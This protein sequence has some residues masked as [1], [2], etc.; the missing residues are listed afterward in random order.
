MSPIFHRVG[1]A[2][3]GRGKIPF[4]PD[5]ITLLGGIKMKAKKIVS[6]VL[7]AAVLAAAGAPADVSAASKAGEYRAYS[8]ILD[9][10]KNAYEDAINQKYDE[11]GEIVN[12]E[13]FQT[14]IYDSSAVPIYRIVDL[15]GDGNDELLIGAKPE[16]INQ[17]DL[18]ALYTFSSGKAV[19]VRDSFG[20][21]AGLLDLR[22]GNVIANYWS[23]SAFE[24]GISYY[25]YE[26]GELK[27]IITIKVTFSE[28]AEEVYTKSENGKQSKSSGD[29]FN[30]TIKKYGLRSS[31]K[32]FLLD[33]AACD[34]LESGNK[35]YSGQKTY[36][37]T[38]GASMPSKVKINDVSDNNTED[39]AGLR[40]SWSKNKY[41]TGY[42]YRCKLFE[43]SQDYDVKGYTKKLFADIH[44]QDRGT[45]TF[46]VRA[47]TTDSYGVKVYGKW[48]TVTYSS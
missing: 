12:P 32:Y 37:L 17:A 16:G 47:Y 11:L 31:A 1:A 39:A 26:A 13:F 42:Q 8:D 24:S 14:F 19:C 35:R 6:L 15:D 48:T 9:E 33:E 45:V 46:Q 3:H 28:S 21:R 25:N 41:A 4:D 22:K 40:F 2:Y 36:T 43:D 10:Y 23:D 27:E 5:I 20:Y 30:A 44:F 38:T 34:A 29:E 18:Y 7:S